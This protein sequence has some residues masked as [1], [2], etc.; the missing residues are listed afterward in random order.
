M[1]DAV[2]AWVFSAMC[3]WLALLLCVQRLIAWR[4]VALRGWPLL[5]VSGVVAVGV[6]LIPVERIA[7]ARWV[8]SI[9]PNF[10]VPLT[11]L[12]A[13]A[14][15]ERAFARPVLTQRDRNAA[16]TF[17]GVA[18]LLLYPFA[19]GVSRIDPYEWGWS[20]SPLFIVV[21]MLTAWL[22]WRR[23]RFGL[24][25]LLA[26]IAFH[27]QLLE[28]SNYWDYLIDPIYWLASL[29]VLGTR[30]LSRGTSFRLVRAAYR[31]G[32]V[33]GPQGTKDEG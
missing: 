24:L 6:L 27:L 10:S 28:S 14:T 15:W 25:L 30:A 22:I 7:L 32:P 11:G 19:L 17:G 29:A 18:G 5:I 4:G 16:W 33:H 2:V 31:P 12:L 9:S 23:N 1:N 3:P 20:A 26:V 13:I 8:A 21:G